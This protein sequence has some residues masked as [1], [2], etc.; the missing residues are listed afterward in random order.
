MNE[1]ISWSSKGH[2]LP[3]SSRSKLAKITWWPSR[4][5]C[6]CWNLQML[7][8]KSIHPNQIAKAC[9]NTSLHSNMRQKV[10]MLH[11]Q[12]NPIES[13]Q[14]T[15]CTQ[16]TRNGHWRRRT[17]HQSVCI[18]IWWGWQD[19]ITAGLELVMSTRVKHGS[20]LAFGNKGNSLTVERIQRIGKSWANTDRRNFVKGLEK[21]ITKSVMSNSSRHCI[22]SRRQ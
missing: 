20:N 19:K 11:H 6:C 5:V 18:L 17:V 13:V 10:P 7:R 16:V 4:N 15:D 1:W 3:S 14:R 12:S 8:D 22:W 9:R 2:M 21:G